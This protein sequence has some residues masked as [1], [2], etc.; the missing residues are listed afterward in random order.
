MKYKTQIS[1]LAMVL[2]MALFILDNNDFESTKAR[3]YINGQIITMED[4]IPTAEA[5]YVKDGIIV[6]LGTNQAMRALSTDK[7]EVID[8]KNKTVLPGF[9]DSHSHVALS[10]FFNAMVDL[11]GF[12]HGSNKA[13]W[14]HLTNAVK[15]KKPGEI[16][17]GKGIDSILVGGLVLPSIQFL[18]SIAPENPVILISQSLH[19]YWANSLAFEAVGISRKTKDPSGSS[20]YGKDNDGNLTGIIIEQQAFLP[21]LDYLKENVLTPEKMVTSTVDS[22]KQ[23]A[24]N[25]NTTVVSTGITINDKKPLRFYE[26]L[27][28]SETGMVN[29]LLTMAGI[30]PEREPFPRHFVYIRFDRLFLLPDERTENDFFNIIGVKHWYDGSPYTGSMYLAEPYKNSDLS[31]I[32]LQLSHD[33]RGTALVTKEK[34]KQFIKQYHGKG[35]QIAIHA[36]GDQA[37]EE[38][39]Q[40]FEDTGLDFSESRHRLEHCVLL[41]ASSMDTL[42][43]LNIFP[44]FHIN[45]LLYY[46][47][48]LKDDLLGE[49]RAE[50]IL[51]IGSAQRAGLK[52]AMHAD[53]PMFESKPLRLIQTAV[54]RKTSSGEVI[55]EEQRITVMDA[56]KAMTIN[57]AYSINMEDRIGSVKEGKYA[58]FIIM[59]KNPLKVP[60][61]DIEKIKI[62]ETYINGNPVQF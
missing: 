31:Q 27:A 38:V 25:G 52:F 18:D 58:D 5:M 50:Q 19:T 35:W 44:N 3:I 6:G 2:I 57:G 39:L 8:L 46:G 16:I 9:I 13:V 59:D 60:T 11:S 10:A 47:D 56:L 29:K 40:I 7:V 14:E 30:F 26:H 51:A 53:Q 17:I 22:M 24:K 33:H 48:A 45:H 62:L 4:N 1:L 23:Y 20:Y 36:Q 43:R 12:T 15:S 41:S 28:S 21:F 54:E 32:D 55:S 34:L 42:K 49:E 37:N 61:A